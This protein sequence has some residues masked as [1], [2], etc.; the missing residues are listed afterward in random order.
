MKASPLIGEVWP[1]IQKNRGVALLRVTACPAAGKPYVPQTV[2]YLND[3]Q[4]L[5]LS[6]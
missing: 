5:C 4:L 2:E 1:E 3:S 6:D